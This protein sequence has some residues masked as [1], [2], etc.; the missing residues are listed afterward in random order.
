M[1]SG[2]KSSVETVAKMLCICG[3]E[4]SEITVGIENSGSYS[5]LI[6][7]EIVVCSVIVSAFAVIDL[8]LVRSI[9]SVLTLA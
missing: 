4:I 9:V 2:I 6:E 8:K 5:M 1:K 3:K 7:S